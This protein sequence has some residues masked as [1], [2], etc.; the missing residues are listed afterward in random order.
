MLCANGSYYKA[1]GPDMKNPICLVDEMII[2]NYD[3]NEI[4]D[5]IIDTNIYEIS[6]SEHV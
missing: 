6:T 5:I 1:P 2:Y 4:K 3:W